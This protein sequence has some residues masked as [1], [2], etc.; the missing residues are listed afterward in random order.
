ME[1]AV[2]VGVYLIGVVK[3]NTKGFCKATIYG[4]MKDWPGGSYIVLR[5]KHM[6]TGERPLI[7]NRYKY[8][9]WKVLSFFAIWWHYIRYSL[10]IEVY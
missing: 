3:I 9:Y 1:S 6:V 8:N 5:I 4:L 7:S 10:F 2:S